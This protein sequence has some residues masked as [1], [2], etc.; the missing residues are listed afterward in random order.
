MNADANPDDKSRLRIFIAVELPRAARESVAAYVAGL[1]EK[2]PHVRAGWER[3][4]K[5]H[6]TLKFLGEITPPRL[7]ALE[8]AAARAASAVGPFDVSIAG[9]GAFPDRG[10]PRVVWLG[11]DDASGGLSLLHK[12]LEEEC[13]LEGFAR[14]PRAFRPHLTA[15]RLRAPEGARA[16]AEFHR[17][18]EFKTDGFTVSDFVVMQS[19]LGPGG[20]RH[21]PLSKHRLGIN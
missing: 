18:Q 9:T 5:L 4:E 6:L 11:V 21:T 16:L 3:P 1:R 14:E 20:S 17:K 13:A 8:R 12:R 19:E 2:F 7:E 15:A 10:L